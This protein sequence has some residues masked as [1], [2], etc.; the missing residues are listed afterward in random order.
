[1][2]VGALLMAVVGVLLAPGA[3]AAPPPG[4]S[5]V[6]AAHAV[7]GLTGMTFTVTGGPDEIT[8][9]LVEDAPYGTVGDYAPLA[10]GRYTAAVRPSGQPGSKPV[11][12]TTF[13][14]GPSSATTL[15]AIGTTAAPRLATLT[16]DLTPPPAGQARVRV[17]PA[18][19]SAPTV[20]VSAQGGPVV[21]DGATFGQASPY[22]DVPAGPWTLDLSGGGKTSTAKVD[23]KAGGV[24]TVAVTDADGGGLQVLPVTDALGTAQAGAAPGGAAAGAPRAAAPGDA[25]PVGGVQTGAGGTSSHTSTAGLDESLWALAGVVLVGAVALSLGR[26]VRA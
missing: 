8:K 10:P 14:V 19:S 21:V 13:S 3:W 4:Q 18:A 16:D 9:A 26:R 12:T 25:A 5:W 17:L 15:A 22:A 6:R 24:Y 1:M 20:D 11:L 23:L 2:G 7:P